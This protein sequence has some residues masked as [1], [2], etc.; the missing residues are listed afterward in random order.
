MLAKVLFTFI[1]SYII[2]V[3]LVYTSQRLMQYHPNKDYPGN[4]KV[5]GLL[6]AKEIKL[7]AEDGQELY[8]WFVAP[9]EKDGKIFVIYHGN[10]GSLAGRAD[11]AS[12]LIKLGYGVYLCEYRGFGGIKGSISEEGLYKDARAGLDWILTNGYDISQLVLYG[13]SIGS[14]VAVEMAKEFNT[15]YLVL[16]GGFSSATAVGKKAYPLFPVS[17]L[18]KDKYDNLSKIKDVKSSLLMIHGVNDKVIDIDVARDLYEAANHPKQF[19][20]FDKGGHVDLFKY[21]AAKIIDNWLKN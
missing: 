7:K 13:E 6:D 10:T 3:G 1:V 2:A 8:A 19:F 21:G 17:V 4:P 11:K 12:D 5:Y 20:E 18:L 15:K 16:E 9:K 14:G